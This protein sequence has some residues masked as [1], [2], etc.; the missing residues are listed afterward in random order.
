MS[1]RNSKVSIIILSYNSKKYLQ[2]CL[3]SINNQSYHD[4]EL[5]IVDN[6]STDGSREYLKR[7]AKKNHYIYISLFQN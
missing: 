5:I 4:I 7:E 2:G 1:K 3:R 6:F